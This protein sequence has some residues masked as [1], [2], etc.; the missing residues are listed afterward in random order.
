MSNRKETVASAAIKA[1]EEPRR[2]ARDRIFETAKNLF[3][4]Q[5][6]RAVG[7][8][9]IAAEA[10]TTKMSLYRSFASKDELVAEC[11]RDHQ[12]EFWKWW[13]GIVAPHAGDPRAQLLALM[14]GFA[15]KAECA[16]ESRGCPLGNAAVELTD[17][18]SPGRAV[19]IEHKTKMRSRL[20]ELCVELGAREANDLADGL[21]L[22]IEGVYTTRVTSCGK[23][24]MQAAPRAAKMLID[25]YTAKSKR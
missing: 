1:A 8:E 9:S 11:L 12:A 25:A 10:G 6:I 3:Y 23:G 17:E 18:D 13:D 24:P 21:L 14:D 20:R 15:G 4:R 19:V 5:G 7:V 2:S 16:R 22:L